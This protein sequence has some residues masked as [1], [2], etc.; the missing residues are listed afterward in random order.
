M[1]SNE[2]HDRWNAETQDMNDGHTMTA[3][4]PL[5]PGCSLYAS[6]VVL[7]LAHVGCEGWGLLA[8]GQLRCPVLVMRSF[9]H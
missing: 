9:I 7:F 3:T 8:A 5:L 1:N 6:M 4:E 2:I